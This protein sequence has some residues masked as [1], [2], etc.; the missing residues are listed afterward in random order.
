M[1]RGVR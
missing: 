1:P